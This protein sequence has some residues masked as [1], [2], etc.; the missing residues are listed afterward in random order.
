MKLLVYSVYDTKGEAFGAPFFAAN[1]NTGLR[2]FKMLAGD[3]RSVI[4]MNPS[5][6]GLFEIGEF[7]NLTGELKGTKHVN[8]GNANMFVNHGNGEEIRIKDIK[9]LGVIK[10]VEKK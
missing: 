1:R 2:S 9:D 8:L 5:D 6:F 4:N 7:D 3:E 10:K